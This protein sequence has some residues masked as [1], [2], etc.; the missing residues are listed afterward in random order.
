MPSEIVPNPWKFDWENYFF[1]G[2]FFFWKHFN[3]VTYNIWT[4]ED[5][6]IYSLV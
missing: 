3:P 5:A 6:Q 4:D 2:E 1:V